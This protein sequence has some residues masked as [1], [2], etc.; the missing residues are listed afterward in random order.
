MGAALLALKGSGDLARTPECPG[1]NR[2]DGPQGPIRSRSPPR[3]RVGRDAAGIAWG[4]TASAAPPRT[5]YIWLR[6]SIARPF[7]S[8]SSA[9]TIDGWLPAA[10]SDAVLNE[11]Y[12]P[13]QCQKMV[14]WTD[15]IAR[16]GKGAPCDVSA[17]P[18]V[19]RLV[20]DDGGLASLSPPYRAKLI[21]RL[22]SPRPCLPP[23]APCAP[24]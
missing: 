24:L 5:P 6:I 20:S 11:K 7:G 17:M 14:R 3:S 2:P 22:L 1:A 18:A 12:R 9:K 15:L 16:L 13:P 8:A 10:R 21:S 23:A 19:P 4:W